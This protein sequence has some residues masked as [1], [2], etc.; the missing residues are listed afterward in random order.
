MK[1]IV[2]GGAGFIGSNLVS[3]LLDEGHEVLNL[4]K[5][6]YAANPDIMYMFAENKGYQFRKVDLTNRDELKEVVK[7]FAP[8]AIM[9]LAAES[10]VDRS[11]ENPQ[12][13]LMTNILGTQ[14]LLDAARR[15]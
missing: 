12:L 11:I 6:T 7:T 10:H 4:D 2:T 3:L 5:L 15:A 1:I 14:N 13:L 8:Q 9:H